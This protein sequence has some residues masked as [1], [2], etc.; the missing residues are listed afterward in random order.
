MG[1]NPVLESSTSAWTE[2]EDNPVLGYSKTGKG[3]LLNDPSV[4]KEG[5]GYRMW[6]TG[7]KPFEL[8]LVVRAYEAKSED[9]ITWTTNF[10][11]ILEPG[12]MGAWDDSRIETV[13]VI[14][15]GDT[16]HLYYAGC[17]TPCNTGQFAI[18]HATSEDG[19]LWVKDADNPLIEAHE[20]PL[21]WGFYTTAEPAVLNHEGTFY[22]YYASA[23][24]NYPDPGSPFGILLATS[25]DGSNFEIH[26]PVYT[27]TD[28]Y[29]IKNFRGY[30]TPTVFMA[31]GLF[32][33]YHDVIHTPKKPSDYHQIAISSAVSE[34]GYTFSEVDTNIM[35]V[36]PGWKNTEIH[37]PAVLKDGDVTKMWF[38]GR[39]DKPK[40]AFGIG[41]ATKQD[42]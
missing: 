16:Y 38:A 1:A 23:K 21:E 19:T 33:L 11:P 24:S 9:G 29:D 10:E 2:Y 36:E 31:D 28:S 42:D 18:G 41:Y 4:I 12:E 34:D 20:N 27:M 17:D 39:T 7:A 37:G 26:G 25:E 3:I 22:L 13:S 35:S 14:R 5:S 15:V 6:A 30:S 8:P 40:F 32:H